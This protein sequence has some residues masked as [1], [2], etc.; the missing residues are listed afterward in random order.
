MHGVFYIKPL[1]FK[2]R[3]D[4]IKERDIQAVGIKGRWTGCHLGGVLG[5]GLWDDAFGRPTEQGRVVRRCKRQRGYPPTR[6]SLGLGGV[7][8]GS[9]LDPKG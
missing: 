7:A 8:P 9:T 6:Q 3:S 1:T 5:A 2:N 4:V